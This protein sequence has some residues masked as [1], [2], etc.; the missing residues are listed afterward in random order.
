MK[1]EEDNVSAHVKA[2]RVFVVHFDNTLQSEE[3][4]RKAKCVANEV[5]CEDF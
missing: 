5:V 3:A 1:I 4:A 2:E